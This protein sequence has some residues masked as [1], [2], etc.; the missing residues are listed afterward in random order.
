MG[1][2]RDGEFFGDGGFEA[3][4]LGLEFVAA[5]SDVEESVAAILIGGRGLDDGGG[6]TF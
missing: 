3:G 2:D 4:G 5:D 1:I 6:N